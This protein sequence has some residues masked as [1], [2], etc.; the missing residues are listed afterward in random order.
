MPSSGRFALPNGVFSRALPEQQRPPALDAFN[1]TLQRQLTASMSA[2]VAYVGNRGRRVFAG[3]GPDVNVNQATLDGYLQGVPRDQ[4]RP[5]FLGFKTPVENLGG[6]FGWTQDIAYF[7]N[8]ANNWYDSMQAKLERRLSG[9]Y[10]Y[11]VSYTLQKARGEGGEYFFF[12]RSLN[13]GVQDWD[14]THNLVISLVAELPF[15]R[16]KRWGSTATPV[17]DAILGGWQFNMNS[18]FLSGLP[19]NVGYND[20]GAGSRHG[21]RP[22]GPDRRPGWTGDALA[23]VQRRAD[24]RVR[25]RLRP[26]GRGNVRLARAQRAARAAL[27]ADRRLAVQ[28]P[29]FRSDQRAPVARRG[30]ERLQPGEPRTAGCHGRRAGQPEPECRANQR[31]AGPQR[32][33]Q[34]AARFSF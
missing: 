3:D 10:S 15:G 17:V 8:C 26:T 34:F 9:G 12:D 18:S 29:A 24:R 27:L 19:F 5:F 4:R 20:S 16:D 6:G 13:R 31:T 32:A 28:E 25:Q 22:A 14:R 33:L 11:R 21:A 7:C 23:V 30:D 1:V 2:E